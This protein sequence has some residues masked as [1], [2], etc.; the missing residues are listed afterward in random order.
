MFLFASVLLLSVPA[1]GG[2]HGRTSRGGEPPSV[3][4]RHEGRGRNY[5]PMR[6][7]GYVNPGKCFRLHPIYIRSSVKL[8]STTHYMQAVFRNLSPCGANAPGERGTSIQ[9]VNMMI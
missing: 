7:L 4:G 8:L 5:K 3:V 9:E 2:R 6:A 1:S